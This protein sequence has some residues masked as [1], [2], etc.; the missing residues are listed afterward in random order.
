MWRVICLGPG[1]L[2]QPRRILDRGPLLDSEAR[3]EAIARR[4]RATGLYERVEV[5]RIAGAP[6]RGPTDALG[7]AG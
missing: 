7:S 1:P 2:D 3:A 4:L 6:P 5:R